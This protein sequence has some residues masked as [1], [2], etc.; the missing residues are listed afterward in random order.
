MK[1]AFASHVALA[2]DRPDVLAPLIQSLRTE[3]AAK[4]LAWLTLGFAAN[5]PYLAAVRAKFRCREYHSRI[6]VVRWSDVG[7]SASEL[8]GR[9]L[10]PEVALL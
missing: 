7:G 8:D 10:A 1:H 3:A 4:K 6:Y 2:P 5:D 9:V